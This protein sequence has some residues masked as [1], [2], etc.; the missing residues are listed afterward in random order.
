MTE[1]I[2][3]LKTLQKCNKEI[4]SEIVLILC[5]ERTVHQMTRHDWNVWIVWHLSEVK[6]KSLTVSPMSCRWRRRWI[7]SKSGRR[8]VL[9][10]KTESGWRRHLWQ[11]WRQ[12]LNHYRLIVWWVGGRKDLCFET[13]QLSHEIEIRRNYLSFGFNVFI[14][15]FHT[16]TFCCHQ[17]CHTYCRRPTDACVTMDQHFSSTT[18]HIICGSK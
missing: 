7:A 15:L 9:I 3:Y 1:A 17:I 10:G 2:N 13:K 5:Y 16:K 18:L 11:E 8:A 14:G 4:E 12:G 6:H